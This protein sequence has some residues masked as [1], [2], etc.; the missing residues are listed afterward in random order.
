[1]SAPILH[2]FAISHYSEKARWALDWLGVPY[3]RQVH[4]PGTQ[5]RKMKA[6]GVKRTSVPV[7]QL[8]D[9][10]VQGS[11]AI[12]D[13][14]ESVATGRSLAPSDPQAAQ[15]E[16]AWLDLELGEMVRSVVYRDLIHD[17]PALVE[18][19]TQDGPWWGK[20]IANLIFPLAR[21]GVA[22]MYVDKPRLL[23]SAE[24]LDAAIR[25][26]DARYAQGPYLVDGRFTRLDLTVAAL[27]APMCTPPEHPFRWPTRP[28]PPQIE[29]IRMRHAAG[30]TLQRVARLYAE[31]R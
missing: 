23:K 2:V 29:A 26:L 9:R 27:L 28:A 8:A 10:S 3:V 21:K 5:A 22:K 30:P 15:D 16:E 14:A 17:R 31:H 1:M 11:S 19:W 12:I 6:L 13:Y 4:L 25:T 20:A 7:L 24:R 18:L